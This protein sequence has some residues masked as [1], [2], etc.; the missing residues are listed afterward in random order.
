MPAIDTLVHD[1]VL[2]PHQARQ[3]LAVHAEAEPVIAV[4][5]LQ[6]LARYET[7]RPLAVHEGL[8]QH[9][10]PA[11]FTQAVGPP[12]LRPGRVPAR[13]RAG[14]LQ[15]HLRRAFEAGQVRRQHQTAV[16]LLHRQRVHFDLA[17]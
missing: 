5:V 11:R 10:V 9:P 16:G 17:G 2:A 6:T 15:L 8:H 13:D 14:P 1:Q 7:V 12:Q 3:Y 4:E